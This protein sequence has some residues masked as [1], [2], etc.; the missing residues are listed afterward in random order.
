MSK[1]ATRTLANYDDALIPVPGDFRAVYIELGKDRLEGYYGVRKTTVLRWLSDLDEGLLKRKRRSFVKTD[2]EKHSTHSRAKSF[3]ALVAKQDRHPVEPELAHMAADFLRC[4]R[5]GGW[6]ISR[7]K[8]GDWL[9]GIS[10]KSS[11]EL[12][13][14]AERKGFDVR[15][16]NLQ[17][18]AERRV[19]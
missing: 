18:Q 1:Q 19:G 10:I 15:A 12:L 3:V 8:L 4:V 13:E 2:R 6:M 5:N 14:M 7:T 17:L 16:A 9:V 11:R